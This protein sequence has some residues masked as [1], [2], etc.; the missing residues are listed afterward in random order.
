MTSLPSESTAT[1]ATAT[2]LP[3]AA[4]ANGLY[5]FEGARLESQAAVLQKQR[6]PVDAGRHHG[7]G[8][9]QGNLAKGAR[10]K[11]ER[12][13][14]Q[15]RTQLEG[16]YES[17]C[18]VGLRGHPATIVWPQRC[19]SMATVSPTAVDRPELCCGTSG[20]RVDSSHGDHDEQCELNKC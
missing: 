13:V 3:A 9:T 14:A 18:V 2:S 16:R 4:T 10:R 19:L 17:G 5:G 20:R 7:R 15:R 8:R 6:W 12:V 1:L 11:R